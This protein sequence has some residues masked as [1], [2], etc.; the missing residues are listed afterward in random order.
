MKV[1]AEEKHFPVCGKS[2][3]HPYFF[4]VTSLG[5]LSTEVLSLS[6]ECYTYRLA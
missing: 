2:H 1:L 5:Y 4:N 3:V 6:L